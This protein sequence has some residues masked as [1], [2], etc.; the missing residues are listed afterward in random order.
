MFVFCHFHRPSPGGYPKDTFTNTPADWTI[1]LTAGLGT[2]TLQSTDLPLGYVFENAT[3]TVNVQLK[4]GSGIA[5]IESN[6][7]VRVYPNPASDYTFVEGATDEI[8]V[9]DLTGRLVLTQTAE[10]EKTM[11]DVTFLPT[12]VYTIHTAGAVTPLLV[13]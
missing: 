3:E 7:A 12:G 8:R 1:D 9:Y 5:N 13:K 4:N 2:Y 11:L 10:G 6:N